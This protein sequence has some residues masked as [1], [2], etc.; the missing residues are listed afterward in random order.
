MAV[1]GSIIIIW[2]LAFLIWFALLP[3]F[4]KIGDKVVNHVKKAQNTD[5][6]GEKK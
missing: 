6:E 4:T 5:K 1:I 2:V 3:K